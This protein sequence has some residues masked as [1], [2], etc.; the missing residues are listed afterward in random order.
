MSVKRG[1]LSLN[2]LKRRMRVK[3][4]TLS[5]NA[6]KR[7]MRIKRRTLPWMPSREGCV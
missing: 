4:G 2:A 1:I 3:R 6:L 5:L 7:R